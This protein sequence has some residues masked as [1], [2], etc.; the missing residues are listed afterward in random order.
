VNKAISLHVLQ[1]AENFLLDERLSAYK[2]ELCHDKIH[3]FIYL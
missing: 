1:M 3:L 2:Q